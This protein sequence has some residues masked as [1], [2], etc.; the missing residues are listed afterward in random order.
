MPLSEYEQRVLAQMEQQLSS[1]DPKLAQVLAAR[2]TRKTTRVVLGVIV[3][4]IGLATLVM[5]VSQS[6]SWLGILGFLVMFAGVLISM[7]QGKTVEPPSASGGSPRPAAQA[8]PRSGFMDRL[9]QRW[10][11]RRDQRG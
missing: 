5:S 9:D 1:D 6:L 10:D 2:G 3:A 4:V 7:S 11:R 8:K